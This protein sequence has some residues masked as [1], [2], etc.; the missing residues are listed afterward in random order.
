MPDWKGMG[1]R[2]AFPR[3]CCQ[4]AGGIQVSSWVLQP[5]QRLLLSSS[6][7]PSVPP[8]DVTARGSVY[9]SLCTLVGLSR[10]TGLFLLALLQGLGSRSEVSGGPRCCHSLCVTG[11]F[12]LSGL[13]SPLCVPRCSP[14]GQC[15]CWACLHRQSLQQHTPAL[16]SF[17]PAV[18]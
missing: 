3:P 17:P 11:E 18:P 14:E 6:P 13:C 4:R 15:R 2:M 1:V 9:S 10:E 5:I 12:A 8:G 16:S 7:C